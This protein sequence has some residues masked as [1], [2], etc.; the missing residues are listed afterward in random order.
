M[1]TSLK[2]ILGTLIVIFSVSLVNAQMRDTT[3]S[4]MNSSQNKMGKTSQEYVTMKGGV[5]ILHQN[6]QSTKLTTT[7]KASDG[8]SISADGTVTKSDGTTMKLKEGDKIYKDGH[9]GTSKST[10]GQKM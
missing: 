6:G 1:K 9:T 2:L 8:T 7:Y 3:S 5:V 4:K 10:S